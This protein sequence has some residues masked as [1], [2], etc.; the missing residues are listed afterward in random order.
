MSTFAQLAQLAQISVG[1]TYRGSLRNATAGDIAVIQMKDVNPEALAKPELL[2]RI[3]LPK[4]L[5]RYLLQPGDLIFRAR[6]LANQAWV[7]ENE[8]PTICIAPLLFIHILQPALLLPRYLQWFINLS[9]TQAQI[10]HMA[11]GRAIRM[12]TAQA[13][14]QLSIPL[15][16]I[17]AQRNVIQIDQMHRE[18][19]ALEANLRAK[20]TVYTE[21][22]LLQVVMTNLVEALP[23]PL[24]PSP[25]FC[26]KLA[27]Q[28]GVTH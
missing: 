9:S 23:M 13:L 14:A 25:S 10:A 3:R 6:G 11:H 8:M 1:Y 26:I 19:Q 15:P 4:L 16:N 7:V 24:A 22:A 20:S 18:S 21:N 5:P 28:N 2:A 27:G 12:I 17:D